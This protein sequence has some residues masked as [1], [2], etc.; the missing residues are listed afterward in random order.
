MIDSEKNSIFIAKLGRKEK[1]L[2]ASCYEILH[3]YFLVTVWPM[4][5]TLDYDEL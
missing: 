4:H 1:I 2:N 5:K 3:R